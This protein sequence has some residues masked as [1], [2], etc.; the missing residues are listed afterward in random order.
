MQGTLFAGEPIKTQTVIFVCEHGSAKSVVAAAH[1]NRIAEKQKLNFHAISRGIN[2]DAELAPAAIKGLQD[3]GVR[4]PSEKPKKL[5]NAEASN[6]VH[7]ITFCDLP[8]DVQV[9]SMERW[10]VSP[11]SEDYSKARDAILKKIDKLI[12]ILKQKP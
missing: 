10:D 9:Q 5:S 7:V 6:A 12:Q 2:P 8:K 3:D 4:L 1:F 11:I